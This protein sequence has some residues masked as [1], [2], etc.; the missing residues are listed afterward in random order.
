VKNV[1]WMPLRF[2]CRF[3]PD[4]TASNRRR[5]S[6]RWYLSNRQFAAGIHPDRFPSRSPCRPP[7]HW[8]IGR[9]ARRALRRKCISVSAWVPRKKIDASSCP[10]MEGRLAH[11]P[12]GYESSFQYHS[13]MLLA[14][15]M[16]SY[17]PGSYRKKIV[18]RFLRK[19]KELIEGVFIFCR[20]A[21]NFRE[22]GFTVL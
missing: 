8:L 7:W 16:S 9:G 10:P 14:T 1:E 21:L 15:P 20:F 12:E 18:V 11:L 4:S 22:S 19:R 13:M 17:V 3:F 5:S 2:S 6:H